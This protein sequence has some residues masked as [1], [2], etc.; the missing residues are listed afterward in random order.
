MAK[1]IITLEDNDEGMLLSAEFNPVCDVRSTLT[2]S[3]RL[4]VAVVATVK[5][6]LSDNGF[7]CDSYSKMETKSSKS[8]TKSP[9]S[10]RGR[11]SKKNTP[12]PSSLKKS[13]K[14]RR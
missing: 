7:A 8:E 10:K 14:A 12:V 3:Q 9:K 2:P 4:G 6:Y 1:V 13:K 5:D 11:P